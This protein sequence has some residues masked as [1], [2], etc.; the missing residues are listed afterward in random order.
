MTS[1]GFTGRRAE[2][3]EVEERGDTTIARVRSIG[4]NERAAVRGAKVEARD[5]IEPRFQEVI[6]TTQLKQRGP[7]STQFLVTISDNED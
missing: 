1:L 7:F 5:V 3:I 2:T 4:V 6:N